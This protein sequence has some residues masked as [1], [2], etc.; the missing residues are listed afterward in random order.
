MIFSIIVA[1]DSNGVIGFNGEMPWK[2][3][4]ADL[5]FFKNTTMHH[6]CILGRKTYNALGNKVLPERKFII[7]TRDNSFKASDSLIVHSIETAMH[8]DVIKNEEEVFILGGGEI[9]KQALPM[10][11]RIYLT[12][13]HDTFEGD[14]YF[15]IPDPENWEMISRSDYSKDEKNPY[16]YSFLVFDR[17]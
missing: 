12:R 1:A 6:W 17:K 14:T 5:Q 3:L 13:I 7:V 15:L 10:V 11:N 2:K 8:L 9:Y 16:N 4:T